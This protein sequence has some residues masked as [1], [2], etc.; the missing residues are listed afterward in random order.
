MDK[1][2]ESRK[3]QLTNPKEGKPIEIDVPKRKAVEANLL[4]IAGKQSDDQGLAEEPKTR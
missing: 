3:T 2:T 1:L 4:K